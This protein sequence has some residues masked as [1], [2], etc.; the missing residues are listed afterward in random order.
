MRQ[1]RGNSSDR[2]SLVCTVSQS[3]L[4]GVNSAVSPAR[5]GGAMKMATVSGPPTLPV[6]YRLNCLWLLAGSIPETVTCGR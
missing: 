1:G 6:R 4:T 2:G 5:D 3:L